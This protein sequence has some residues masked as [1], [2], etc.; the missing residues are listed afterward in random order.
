MS[1]QPIVM[2]NT[3]GY[4]TEPCPLCGGKLLP[5]QK[6]ETVPGEWRTRHVSCPQKE[7]PLCDQPHDEPYDGSCLL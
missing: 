4:G 5:G 3:T 6:R 2:N 7:C 1:A